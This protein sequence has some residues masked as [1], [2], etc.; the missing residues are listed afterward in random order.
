MVRDEEVTALFMLRVILHRR[1]EGQPI[2]KSRA[3]VHESDAMRAAGEN[4]NFQRYFG[5]SEATI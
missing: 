5:H 1:R 3:R 2:A 4:H